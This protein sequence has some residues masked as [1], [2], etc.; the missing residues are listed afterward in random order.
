MKLTNKTCLVTGGTR[1]IGAAAAIAFA[2][3]GADVAIVGR[4]EDDDARQTLKAIRALGRRGELILAD[5]AK[6][7]DC[8]RAVEETAKRLGGLDVLVHSEIGRAHV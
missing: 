7:A 4:T 6:P 5:C 8:T 2:K 1:G 3:E